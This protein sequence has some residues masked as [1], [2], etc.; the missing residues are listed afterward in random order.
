V[1]GVESRDAYLDKIG[2]AQLAR[3]RSNTVAGYAL[4]LDRR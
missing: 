3:I 1:Y 4:G 2:G